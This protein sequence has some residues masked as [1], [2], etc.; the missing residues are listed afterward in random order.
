MPRSL[1]PGIPCKPRPGAAVHIAVLRR[2]SS[3]P[4]GHSRPPGHCRPNRGRRR[5]KPGWS[6]ISHMCRWH[7]KEHIFPSPGPGGAP[8]TARRWCRPPRAAAIRIECTIQPRPTPSDGARTGFWHCVFLMQPRARR[9]ENQLSDFCGIWPW[10]SPVHAR[11]RERRVSCPT[12]V[13]GRRTGDTGTGP[14]GHPRF[15]DTVPDHTRDGGPGPSSVG[16]RPSAAR[17]APVPDSD[18]FLRSFHNWTVQPRVGICRSVSTNLLRGGFP[19]SGG[20]APGLS[21]A[22]HR[23]LGWPPWISAV[24]P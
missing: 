15:G 7:A 16:R 12:P 5:R 21:F 24:S 13:P 11:R 18:P 22:F 1:E 2:R 17:F 10:P 20:N 19:S 14:A 3:D 6:R 4:S 8:G 23:C 9:I